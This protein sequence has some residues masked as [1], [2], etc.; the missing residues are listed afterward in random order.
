MALNKFAYFALANMLTIFMLI[1]VDLIPG[2][3]MFIPTVQAI[4]LM[5]WASDHEE[6]R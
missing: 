6:N 4:P 3:M 5:A 1:W 2:W